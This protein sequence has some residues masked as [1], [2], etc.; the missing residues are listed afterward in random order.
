MHRPSSRSKRYRAQSHKGNEVTSGH[1]YLWRFHMQRARSPSQGGVFIVVLNYHESRSIPL[2]PF[3]ISMQDHREI[4]L[5]YTVRKLIAHHVTF[6]PPNLRVLLLDIRLS[7]SLLGLANVMPFLGL[8]LCVPITSDTSD[9]SANGTSDTV[10]DT[11][12]EVVKLTLSFL[13][14]A[15]SVLLGA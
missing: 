7:T 2:V 12:A 10:C 9:A 13:T 3:P 15:F 8:Q 5:S 6:P 14:L 4:I 1:D 11:S